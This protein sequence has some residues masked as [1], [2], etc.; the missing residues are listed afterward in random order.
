MNTLIVGSSGK[1]GI[2]FLKKKFKNFLYTY[3]SNKFENGIKFNILK[4][5]INLIIKKH[6]VSKIILLSAISD[7][8]ICFKKKKYSNEINI[9]K[10][11]KIIKECIKKNIYIIFLSSEFVY[12]GQK[13]KYLETNKLFP[14]NLYGKQ[15]KKVEFFLKKNC[16][17]YCILRIAKT[18]SDNMNDNTL[19]T[20]FL[21][22]YLNRKKVFEASSD[23]IFNP[24]YVNDLIKIIFFFQKKKIKGIFNI[25]G[26]KSYSRYAL[27][28]MFVKTAKKLKLK[29]YSPIVKK[30]NLSEISLL[31]KR[32]LNV[33][34]NINKLK[35]LINFKINSIEEIQKKIITQRNASRISRR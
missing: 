33:S 14:K 34:M 16:K 22:D 19:V 27:I 4:D 5:D 1:I 15:K 3:N 23:Q 28:K 7:P 8:D 29:N 11:I 24:L 30:I 25:G 31:E 2:H 13:K 21:K 17:N 9:I 26:P 35:K 6:N 18:Y 20:G 10:T 32:P 12:D